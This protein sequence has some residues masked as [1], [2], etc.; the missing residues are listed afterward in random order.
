M[1]K[2]YEKVNRWL[3][4]VFVILFVV[5]TVTF[6]FAVRYA[7]AGGSQTPGH[8]LTYT[9]NRL[10]W[11]SAT[12]IDSS[13]AAVLK[14]FGGEKPGVVSGNVVAPGT[15]GGNS[16]RLCNDTAG[17]VDYTAVLYRIRSSEKL[18][19]AAVLTGT[20]LKDTDT[21]LLPEGVSDDQVIRAVTGKLGGRQL[22]DF[23]IGWSWDFHESVQQDAEDTLMGIR[24]ETVTLG[25]HIVIEDDNAELDYVTPQTGDNGNI[26]MHLTILLVS[27]MLLL[28][29]LAER[30]R[31]CEEECTEL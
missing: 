10:R 7:Y 5:G 12:G 19:V 9:R 8:V 18:A 6:S 28:F 11:D 20:D 21:Y 29:L 30:K 14:L 16:V 31:E 27:S 22:Q 15:S 26:Y 24:G 3:L 23:D 25:L 1:Q 17:E 13:G 4:P 2:L